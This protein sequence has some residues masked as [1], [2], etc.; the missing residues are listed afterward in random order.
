MIGRRSATSTLLLAYVSGGGLI[1]LVWPERGP[2]GIANSICRG[3]VP[4]ST[5][6]VQDKQLNL[7]LPAQKNSAPVFSMASWGNSTSILDV[8]GHHP[9]NGE[10]RSF[11]EE[12][13]RII[14]L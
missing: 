3:Q 12:R 13:K 7:A 14:I 1:T 4:H 11:H 2:G 9:W 6:A 5:R 10:R 8:R